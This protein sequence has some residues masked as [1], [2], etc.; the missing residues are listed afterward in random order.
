MLW[1]SCQTCI[2]CE[3]NYTENGQPVT[4]SEEL[5]AENSEELDAFQDAHELTASQKGTT[6]ICTK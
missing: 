1:S 3:Y 5:C 6:A 2:T 4:V